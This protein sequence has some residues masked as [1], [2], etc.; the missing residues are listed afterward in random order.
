MVELA[1]EDSIN[2]ELFASLPVPRA[3]GMMVLPAIANQ[4]IH[5]VYNIAD[6]WFV[7]LTGNPDAVAAVSL[8]IENESR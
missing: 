4:I 7:G 2:N 8:C 3:V 5:V 1:R 6:T